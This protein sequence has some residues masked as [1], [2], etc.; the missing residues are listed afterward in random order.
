[1]VRTARRKAYVGRGLSIKGKRGVNPELRWHYETWI[2]PCNQ[3]GGVLDPGANWTCEGG[4]MTRLGSLVFCATL[5]TGA[6]LLSCGGGSDGGAG[7]SGG[8][9][10]G[11]TAGTDVVSAIIPADNTVSG[12]TRDPDYPETA[13]KVAALATTQTDAVA[14]IDG[15]A[16][17]FYSSTFSA[18]VFAWQNYFNPNFTPDDGSAGYYLKLYVLQMPSAAQATALYDSLVDGT[19]SLYSTNAYLL[20][21]FLPLPP[22]SI[23]QVEQ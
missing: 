15:G 23:N 8:G 20:F 13:T 21:N 3:V 1:M 9:G 14:L 2:I 6:V 12:W 4:T 7:G 18:N 10:A 22:D 19:H 11:G 5:G 17:P 16:D